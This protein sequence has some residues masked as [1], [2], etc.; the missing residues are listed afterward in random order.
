MAEKWYYYQHTDGMVVRSTEPNTWGTADNYMLLSTA[1]GEKIH[2]EQV[3]DLLRKGV[4]SGSTI[5][6]VIRWTGQERTLREILVYAFTS[7][8]GGCIS[9]WGITQLVAAL[10]GLKMG[11]EGIVTELTPFALVEV[12][13]LALYPGVPF[14]HKELSIWSFMSCAT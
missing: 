12:L 5:Y 4:P 2:H 13:A 8:Q 1:D 10:L 3:A 14:T 9:P 6:T 11:K 7:V